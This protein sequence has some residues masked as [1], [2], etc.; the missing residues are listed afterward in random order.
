MA[1]ATSYEVSWSAESSDSLNASA[2]ALPGVTGTTTTIQH[3]ALV[4][5][6]LTVTVTPEYIDENGVTQQLNELAGTATLAVGPSGQRLESGG[7]T[8]GGN[9]GSIDSGYG[10]VDFPVPV[11][12]WRFEYDA[13]DWVGSSHGTESGGVAFEANEEGRGRR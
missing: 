2:G 1:N 3:D 6:T 8:N 9:G 12:H 7:G 5:M 11:S 13:V 10:A 4:P